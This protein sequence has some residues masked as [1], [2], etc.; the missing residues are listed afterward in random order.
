MVRE[1]QSII[2]VATISC[3]ANLGWEWK[4]S[5]ESYSVNSPAEI[6]SFRFC[7]FLINGMWDLSIAF[8]EAI[9]SDRNFKFVCTTKFFG[10]YAICQPHGIH[11]CDSIIQNFILHTANLLQKI[12][13]ACRAWCLVEWMSRLQ[14]ICFLETLI[15]FLSDICDV[16]YN[17]IWPI[18]GQIYRKS[19]C[20]T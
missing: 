20:P 7:Q 2:S 10:L 6:T 5:C 3:S 12:P 8:V 17:D 19:G 14:W 9:K 18:S 15:M 13:L 11:H 16:V 1:V 4:L